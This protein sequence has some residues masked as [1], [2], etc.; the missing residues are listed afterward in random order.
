LNINFVQS[1]FKQVMTLY[2]LNKNLRLNRLSAR[3]PIFS[4][5]Q[6]HLFFKKP[7]KAAN[8]KP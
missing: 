2:S 7:Q 5:G 6:R 3:L 4:P 8:F 1:G